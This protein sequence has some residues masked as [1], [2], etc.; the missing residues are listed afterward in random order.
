MTLGMVLAALDHDITV[1]IAQSRSYHPEYSVG[2][3]ESYVYP[4]VQGGAHLY[5]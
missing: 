5:R 1:V 2:E 4:L 3:G